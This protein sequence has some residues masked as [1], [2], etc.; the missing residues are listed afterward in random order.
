MPVLKPD[1]AGIVGIL[2]VCIGVAVVEDPNFTL[3]PIAGVVVAMDMGVAVVITL[4]EMC[5]IVVWPT[6]ETGV[7]LFFGAARSTGTS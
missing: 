1:T 5:C 3:L 2:S 6:T 4:V 7:D